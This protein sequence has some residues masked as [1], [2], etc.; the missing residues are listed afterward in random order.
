MIKIYCLYYEGKYTPDYVT[1]LYHSLRRNCKVD[2]T[3]HCYS[4]SNVEADEVIPLNRTGL[5]A[6]H[7]HKLR[8]FDKSF[9]GEGDIIVMDID[10]VIVSDITE[11]INWPIQEDEL[12]SYSKWWNLDNKVK[13]NGGW[14]KFKAG[15]LDFIW[16]KY[17][18]DP[19][20]WQQY[21]Y[22]KIIVDY[23]FFGEQNFVQDTCIENAAKI[24]HMPG[25]W[26]GK[27]TH[28]FQQNLSYQLMYKETFDEEFM[29]MG[30]EINPKLK[31]VHFANPDN[32]IHQNNYNW[33]R[34]NWYA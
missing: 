27:W 26:V 2:F 33:V 28:N 17:L 12:V 23:K 9:T 18:S 13:I 31:I 25:E 24:T 11:M 21:Y 19:A 1:K 5:I 7:W 20:Y 29:I 34:D 16:K 3:F 22:N 14:Y 10:Q 6:E 4:D 30:D 8:F 32:S 15:S